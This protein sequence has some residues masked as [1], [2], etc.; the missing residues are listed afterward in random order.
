MPAS[1]FT[2]QKREQVESI[3]RDLQ[4]AYAVLEAVTQDMKIQGLESL[5]VKNAETAKR[6]SSAL[7]AYSRN[8]SDAWR[9]LS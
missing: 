4:H 8:V 6:K 5:E 2:K 7:V 9:D 1:K 3:K